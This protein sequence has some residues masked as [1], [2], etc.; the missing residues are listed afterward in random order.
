MDN[1]FLHH[2]LHHHFCRCYVMYNNTATVME[3]YI[4]HIQQSHANLVKNPFKWPQPIF[5]ASRSSI[6]NYIQPIDRRQK[7]RK[8]VRQ[9]E[10]YIVYQH[11]KSE[12]PR[13]FGYKTVRELNKGESVS[14]MLCLCMKTE[15]YRVLKVIHFQDN[16]ERRHV[17]HSMYENERKSLVQLERGGWHCATLRSL[18]VSQWYR[19]APG[20]SHGIPPLGES[21]GR[22][23]A[24]LGG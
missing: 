8:H 4:I 2:F 1:N 15:Q 12:S 13:Y 9:R 5:Y 20:T 21:T 23:D 3:R 14:I 18:S 10:Q 22:H 7:R 24:I 6:N 19:N 17:Y 16:D 11:T